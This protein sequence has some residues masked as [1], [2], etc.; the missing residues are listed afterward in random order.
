MILVRE[1][2][3]QTNKHNLKPVENLTCFWALREI[4]NR[5]ETPGGGNIRGKYRGQSLDLAFGPV[6]RVAEIW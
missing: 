4:W 6:L 5:M 2:R 3:G 1:S